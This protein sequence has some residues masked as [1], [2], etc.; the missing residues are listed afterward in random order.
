M[1][2]PKKQQ[3]QHKYNRIRIRLKAYDSR[4]LDRAVQDIIDTAKRTGTKI[5][6]PIPLP[7]KCERFTVLSSPHIDKKARE[8]FEMRTHL[9]MLD[10]IDTSAAALEALQN[11][12]FSAGVDIQIK[13]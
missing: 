12:K 13:A 11:L 4:T 6:G 5:A 8:Q 3:Q 10:L 1:A 7:T 9:R 2:T